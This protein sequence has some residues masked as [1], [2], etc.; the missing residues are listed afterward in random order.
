MEDIIIDSFNKLL[1]TK[2]CKGWLIL[3]K[4]I[5]VDPTFKAYK[6]Y[7]YT[8]Y[9]HIPKNNINL[10]SVS[11]KDRVIDEKTELAIKSSLS[12]NLLLELYNFIETTKF[13]DIV[14]NEYGNL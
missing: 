7:V 11:I 5:N 2:G 4:N 6:E 12:K 13:K 3:H 8:V 14:N 9:L 1:E 10:F